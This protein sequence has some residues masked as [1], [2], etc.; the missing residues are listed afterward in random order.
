M[1][2]SVRTIYLKAWIR[3]AFL[4]ATWLLPALFAMAGCSSDPSGPP[5]DHFDGARFRL[6]G[7]DGH[8]GFLDLLRWRFSREPGP[9]P[10]TVENRFDGIPPPRV[11]GTELRVWFVGHA[12]VLIQTAGPEHPDR[13]V[14]VGARR[15]RFPGWG[16][17]RVRAPGVRFENLPRI[18]AVL[19]SHN[20]YDHLD[21][22]ALARLWQRDKPRILGPARQRRGDRQEDSRR[23]P[24]LGRIAR[25]GGR[26]GGPSGADAALVG[27]RP[28]RPQQGA[29]GRVRDRDAGRQRL[30]R[31]AI[32]ATATGGCSDAPANVS[33]ASGSPCCRSARTS[34][35]GS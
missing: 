18:D 13:S 22:S 32:R 21:R 5:S 12:T 2:W 30:F 10:E 15:P 7:G 24:G 26:R 3:S 6:A 29:V 25:T 34:R 35:A 31:G 28:V 9:W 19:V 33:A 8:R 11:E 16:P 17:K 14:L 27:A 20:H 23:D 4:H 1:Q